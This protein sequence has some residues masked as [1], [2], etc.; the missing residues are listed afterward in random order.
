MLSKSPS[1]SIPKACKNWSDIKATYRLLSSEKIEYQDLIEAIGKATVERAKEEELILII[2]DTTEF[3]L[4]SK[5]GKI[6]GL[7]YIRRNG[8]YGMIMHSSLAVTREGV[9]LGIVYQKY[10]ER[11]ERGI[12]HKRKERKYKEKESSKWEEVH[13]ESIKHF[14]DKKT[15]TICDREADIYE[16]LVY[17]SEIREKGHFVLIRATHNRELEG[18]RRIKETLKK[19]DSQGR[20]IVEKR[21]G[22]GVRKVIEIE[23]KFIKTKIRPPVGKEGREIEVTIIQGK[24]KGIEWI[25]ITT[26]PVGGIED[27][28]QCIEWYAQRWRIESY[29]YVLKSGCKI[30]EIQLEEVRKIKKLIAIYSIVAWKILWMIYESRENPEQPCTVILDDVEWKL[31]Y[32]IAKKKKPPKKPMSLRE[33]VRSIAKLGGFIGRKGDGEPGVKTLW[34]G[35]MEFETI[36]DGYNTL[37]EVYVYQGVK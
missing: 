34:R 35:L 9:P 27:A 25:L 26:Y 7:G 10:W 30:E 18:G 20:V 5:K 4:T 28:I 36:K 21:D 33:A 16:Y 22:R 14:K 37:S 11:K 19:I 32:V 2:Q 29:H 13:K 8:H 6:K 15:L 17:C 12:K 23:V 3:D 31:L 24:G 1:E